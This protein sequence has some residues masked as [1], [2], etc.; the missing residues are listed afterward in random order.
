MSTCSLKY[1]HLD[2]V[3]RHPALKSSSKEFF[4]RPE[5]TWRPMVALLLYV[6]DVSSNKLLGS[7]LEADREPSNHSRAKTILLTM[8]IL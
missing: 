1:C 7:D 2:F 6:Y 8:V 3:S 4:E 5:K